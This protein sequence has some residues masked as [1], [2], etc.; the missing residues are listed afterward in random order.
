MLRSLALYHADDLLD[1]LNMYISN[2]AGVSSKI[3]AS[4]GMGVNLLDETD[5]FGDSDGHSLGS[6]EGMS[7]DRSVDLLLGPK[8]GVRF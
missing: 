2:G 3:G 6:E 8:E 7:L 5:G 4:E 1:S